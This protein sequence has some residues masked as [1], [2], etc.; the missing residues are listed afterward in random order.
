MGNIGRTQLLVY[1]KRSMIWHHYFV[2]YIFFVWTND[3][4]IQSLYASTLYVIRPGNMSTQYI[5]THM[6]THT[7]M[8]SVAI[9]IF[10]FILSSFPFVSLTFHAA[11]HRLDRLVSGLLI[12]AR[13]AFKADIFRQQVFWFINLLISGQIS[14]NHLENYYMM[15]IIH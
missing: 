12:L 3:Q 15:V 6:Y 13:T 10:L 9:T 14:N 11:I 5:Q 7:Y 8:F 2:S 1:F 4:N